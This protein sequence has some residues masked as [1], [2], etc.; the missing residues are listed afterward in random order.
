[1]SRKVFI[2]GVPVTEVSDREAED[3]DFVVCMPEGPSEF[4]DNL[5]GYCCKCD[6]RIMY[7]W[8]APRKP[9]K[10]CLDCATKLAK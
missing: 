3:V 8:H 9:K 5:T 1:M 2:Q 4:D 6:A 7:R 10:I